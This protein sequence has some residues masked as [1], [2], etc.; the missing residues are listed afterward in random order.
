MSRNQQRMM[1]AQEVA[2]EYRAAKMAGKPHDALA[3]QLALMIAADGMDSF[4]P[5]TGICM[6]LVK[7]ENKKGG[8][9]DTWILATEL[10]CRLMDKFLRRPGSWDPE[11]ATLN[12]WFN[13]NMAWGWRSIKRR[14]QKT[15]SKKLK[16]IVDEETGEATNPVDLAAGRSDRGEAWESRKTAT[17]KEFVETQLPDN[18]RIVAL[19]CWFNTEDPKQQKE[20]ARE[21]GVAEGTVALWKK[22]AGE[23]ISDFV[24]E[25][26]LGS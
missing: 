15:L 13:R 3:N 23:A 5:V 18:L 24:L 19:N 7:S 14:E 4:S 25:M 6:A 21:H 10:S 22:K 17:V 20:I 26:G 2:I 12:T 1:A 11:K 9:G 8:W 16:G